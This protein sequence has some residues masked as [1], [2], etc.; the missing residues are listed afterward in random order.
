MNVAGAAPT[1]LF[2]HIYQND[3]PSYLCSLS[4]TLSQTQGNS[5]S[6]S[7]L[8]ARISTI[9]TRTAPAMIPFGE[10]TPIGV[11][12]RSFSICSLVSLVLLLA[13]WLS[14]SCLTTAFKFS[15]C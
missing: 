15:V 2:Y 8:L 5:A 9:A 13:S 3:M 4:E 12:S 11:L 7:T 10:A 1:S 14:A 6:R